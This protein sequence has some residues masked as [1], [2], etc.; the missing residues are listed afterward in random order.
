MTPLPHDIIVVKD[1]Y[2]LFAEFFDETGILEKGGT[3][4]MTLD[5]KSALLWRM[6]K[7]SQFLKAMEAC[8]GPE[9]SCE[10]TT[11]LCA[12]PSKVLDE[13]HGPW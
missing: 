5:E 1:F 3:R 10:D 7:L 2:Q 9:S 6:E 8:C 12:G 11:I 4:I 13:N